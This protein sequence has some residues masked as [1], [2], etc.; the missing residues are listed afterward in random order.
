MYKKRVLM[1]QHVDNSNF[2][3]RSWNEFRN[4]FGVCQKVP[5]EPIGFRTPY[6]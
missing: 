3:D 4:G 6:D 5:I 2:F 1:Q